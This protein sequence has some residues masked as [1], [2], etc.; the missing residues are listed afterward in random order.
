MRW[1]PP[2]VGEVEVEVVN[3]L[4]ACGLSRSVTAQSL[5][6]LRKMP[7]RRRSRLL[8]CPL[9]LRAVQPRQGW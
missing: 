3:L 1:V 8:V 4:L 9:K 7:L 2:E 5:G 6:K